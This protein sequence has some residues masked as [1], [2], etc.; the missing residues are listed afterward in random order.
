MGSYGHHRC[1]VKIERVAVD[2]DVDVD[3]DGD[4]NVNLVDSAVDDKFSRNL[5]AIKGISIA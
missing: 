5:S 1:S 3:L 4:L 2:L